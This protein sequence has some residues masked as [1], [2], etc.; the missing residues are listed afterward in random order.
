VWITARPIDSVLAIDKTLP[1]PCISSPHFESMLLLWEVVVSC[2]RIHSCDLAA[3]LGS[4]SFEKQQRYLLLGGL[5]SVCCETL[6]STVEHAFAD[7]NLACV[8]FETP[9]AALIARL[10]A[11]V[12]TYKPTFPRSVIAAGCHCWRSLTTRFDRAARQ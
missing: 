2:D 9:T 1:G 4:S 8:C 10:H 5:D 3:D 12:H 6:C 7:D 11:V